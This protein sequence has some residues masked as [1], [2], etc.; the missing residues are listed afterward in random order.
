MV[1]ISHS[2]Q[3]NTRSVL[4]CYINGK[5]TFWIRS[6]SE[7]ASCTHTKHCT[8]WQI[9][10]SF[11]VLNY[12]FVVEVVVWCMHKTRSSSID[13]YN[14][15]ELNS[16]TRKKKH[17]SFSKS[18]WISSISCWICSYS[19]SEEAVADLSHFNSFL[20]SVNSHLAVSR[21]TARCLSS[22]VHLM[23]SVRQGS[24]CII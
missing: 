24:I 7:M 19:F 3:W 10:F 20:A 2:L 17:L 18:I 4:P 22:W 12:K 23:A 15:N 16:R 5:P 11:Y 8:K 21:L 9:T 1:P 13:Y 14:L 6:R